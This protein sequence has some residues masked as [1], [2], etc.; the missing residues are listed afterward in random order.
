MCWHLPLFTFVYKDER[1]KYLCM[2]TFLFTIR[3]DNCIK[4]NDCSLYNRFEEQCQIRPY[5]VSLVFEG[6]SYTWKDLE[7]GKEYELELQEARCCCGGKARTLTLSKYYP[8]H[9]AH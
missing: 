6:T 1:A 2:F 7:L 5:A 8:A 4:E 9:C 3:F